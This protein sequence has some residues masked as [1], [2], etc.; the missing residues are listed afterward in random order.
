MPNE[1][2]FYTGKVKMFAYG[3]RKGGFGRISPAPIAEAIFDH[4]TKEGR[5]QVRLFVHEH[6]CLGHCVETYPI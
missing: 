5:N 4:S 1:E 3:F 2:P 6:L